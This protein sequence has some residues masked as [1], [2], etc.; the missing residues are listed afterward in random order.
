MLLQIII[1]CIDN[2][3]KTWQQI[4][5]IATVKQWQDGKQYLFYVKNILFLF[6]SYV[7]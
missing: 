6:N 4:E 2:K 5:T 3:D 7:R 1:F